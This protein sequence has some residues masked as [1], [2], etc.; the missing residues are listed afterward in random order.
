VLWYLT[1]A[2][3]GY[4]PPTVREGWTVGIK[5]A[6]RMAHS[7][8]GLNLAMGAKTNG[9]EL[10]GEASPLIPAWQTFEGAVVTNPITG[11]PFTAVEINALQMAFQADAA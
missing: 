10:I 11:V 8:G 7:A 5:V 2:A 1:N 9:V 6:A 4:T 3:A